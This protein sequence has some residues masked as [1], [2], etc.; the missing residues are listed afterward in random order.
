MNLPPPLS[1]LRGMLELM[2]QGYPTRIYRIYVGPIH[3]WLRRFYNYVLPTMKP[4]SR[5]K[6]ILL[7]EAPTNL[8]NL[9][10]KYPL[11]NMRCDI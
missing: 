11:F 8:E 1:V 2:Q 4:R 10:G 7:S 9:Q 6:I 5:K 3:P